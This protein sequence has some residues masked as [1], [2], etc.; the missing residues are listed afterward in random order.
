MYRHPDSSDSEDDAPSELFYD[1]VMATPEYRR[2]AKALAANKTIGKRK[3]D[4]GD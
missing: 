3:R 2:I 1:D 4:T